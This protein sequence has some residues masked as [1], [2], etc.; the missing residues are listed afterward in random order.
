MA[1]TIKAARTPKIMKNT[2]LLD[3]LD[4]Y[5][6]PI[7]NFDVS[8]LEPCAYAVGYNS[9]NQSITFNIR[10]VLTENLV[11][12]CQAKLTPQ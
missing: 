3:A 4:P 10:D 6:C 12:Y 8:S 9:K 11:A 7:L 2:L 5:D 1:S